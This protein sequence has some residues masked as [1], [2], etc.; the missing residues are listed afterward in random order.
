MHRGQ[1]DRLICASYTFKGV[2]ARAFAVLSHLM[3]CD[4]MSFST[5]FQ[6]YQDGGCLIME[7]HVQCNSD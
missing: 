3:S 6:S 2:I 7:G 4:F 1:K 5:V